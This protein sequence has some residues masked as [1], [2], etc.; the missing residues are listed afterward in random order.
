MAD[1]SITSSA[2]DLV[3]ALRESEQRWKFALEGN[4]DG[5]WDWN[6]PA[7]TMFYSPTYWQILGFEHEETNSSVEDFDARVHAAD[8]PAVLE[9]TVQLLR[10]DIP[11]FSHEYRLRCKDG[12]YKWVLSRGKVVKRSA[13]GQPERIIGT[14]SDITS[15]KAVEADLQLASEVFACCAEAIL[16]TDQENR[17]LSVNH[18][19]TEI[20]GYLP[21]EAIGQN[22][23][24]LS[25]GRQDGAFFQSMWGALQTSGHWRGEIWNRRKNGRVYPEWL[26]ISVVRE[27][28][29]QVS[30][31]I[32]IF[33]DISDS[34]QAA[35]RLQY[36]STHDALTG[37][38]NLVQLEERLKQA[39]AKAQQQH[40]HVALISLSLNHL[41]QTNELLGHGAG[42]QLLKITA[43]RLQQLA[44]EDATVSRQSGDQFHVLLDGMDI[45]GTR[46]FAQSALDALSEFKLL[47][48]NPL[49]VLPCIGASLYPEHGADSSSLL[50]SADAAMFH[51]AEGHRHGFQFFNP[52]M[53]AG[54]LQ[55]MTL[56]NS[57]RQALEQEEFLIHFQPIFDLRNNRI[58]GAEALLRWKH[59]EMDMVSPTVF[60]ELAEEN[61]VIVPL[62]EWMMQRVCRHIH[63]WQTAGIRVV[64]ISINLSARQFSQ[65]ELPG[66]IERMIKQSGINPFFLELEIT[67]NTLTEKLE[68]ARKTI[69]M[70][71][72]L[73]V[74]VNVDDFGTGHSS[75]AYLKRFHIDKLKIDPSFI[76]NLMEDADDSAIVRAMISM[77]HSMR[78]GIVAE[79]VET[80]KQLDFLTALNCDQAQGFFF[81]E[82]L[83]AEAFADLL[84][85]TGEV[86]ER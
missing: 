81:S 4:G 33:S 65:A 49:A 9:S 75:L 30:R 8:K 52:E 71:K 29:G 38:A 12:S 44:P 58:I 60:I 31:Y 72:K 50:E 5:V 84:K 7:N 28:S 55:R 19:F 73:G 86:V 14:I 45:D 37:L 22:P 66:Q 79:G 54:A 40:G 43:E 63:D 48:G 47:N 78:L 64:P 32:G 56:E 35:E 57:L 15:R 59:P 24:M 69:L 85:N 23:R 80:Q 13:D 76:T 6:I 1:L 83:P 21:E 46:R 42:D 77:A 34:K 2:E 17:I 70:L 10:G 11:V 74:R 25:S 82:A 20:T 53:N 26:S 16:I 36:L 62:G 41:R 68:E 67:E 51:L 3:N 39:I 18:A 27:P 61:G